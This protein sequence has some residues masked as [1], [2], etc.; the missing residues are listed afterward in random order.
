VS[1]RNDRATKERKK[2]RFSETPF[3]RSTNSDHSRTPSILPV[4]IGGGMGPS[5]LLHRHDN[6][7]GS[8]PFYL[9][10]LVKLEA[11]L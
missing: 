2:H 5:L 10:H 1:S 9:L 11:S 7:H 4:R 6:H 8:T 3:T